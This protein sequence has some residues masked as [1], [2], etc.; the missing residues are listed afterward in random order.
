[1]LLQFPPGHPNQLKISQNV[2]SVR[3]QWPHLWVERTFSTG[4]AAISTQRANVSASSCC[5]ALVVRERVNLHSNSLKNPKAN[6]VPVVRHKCECDL[7]KPLFY[8]SFSEI[9]YVDATSEDT[10]RTDLEAIPPG[11]SKRTVDA[12]LR[13]LA[14]QADINWLLIF[15]NADNVDL[16][17]KR[18]FP[19]CPSG[20]ILVTT[21]NRELRHYTGKDADAD[22]KGMDLEDAK[23]LLLVQARAESN[24]EN[25]ALAETIVQVILLMPS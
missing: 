24:V 15:D 1:M 20:N 2:K 9:F 19:S 10:I 11:N 7:L 17:L 13:W 22:V 8:L 14:N 5:M 4:C 21:R 6:G 23:S 12:S 16:K 18:Y 3:R 25:N